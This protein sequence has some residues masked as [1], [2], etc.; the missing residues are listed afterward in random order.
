MRPGHIVLHHHRRPYIDRSPGVRA[1]KF[2][3]RDA[4]DAEVVLVQGYRSPD[5]FWVG[6]EMALPQSIADDY[7][8]MR[9][10]RPIFFGKK[11]AADQCF[12]TEVAKVVARNDSA[13]Y[14]LRLPSASKVQRKDL[15]SDQTREDLIAV[16]E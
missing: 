6:A 13:S 1:A 8:R 16:P 10:R 11:A 4:D 5:D 9:V 15:V 2:L 12:H 3:W 14:A 7:D